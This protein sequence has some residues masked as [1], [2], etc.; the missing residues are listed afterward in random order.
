[1][2]TA[3]NKSAVSVTDETHQTF[4]VRLQHHPPHDTLTPTLGPEGARNYNLY[5][6][7]S[8][9]ATAQVP[10]VLHWHGWSDS[11]DDFGGH[12]RDSHCG[13]FEESEARGFIFAAVCGWG[14]PASFNAGTCCPPANTFALDDV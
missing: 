1:M 7:K 6:P 8:Y 3:A 13:F 11:C 9:N 12:C 5:I 2:A 10:L 14:E 4:S